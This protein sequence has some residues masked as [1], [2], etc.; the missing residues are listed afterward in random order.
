[1]IGLAH[2]AKME[3]RDSASLISG[4]HAFKDVARAVL[5]FARDSECTGVMSQPKNNLG[6]LPS[7]SLEYRVEEVRIEVEDGWTG[8]P[9]FV[10]G[11]A[12][13]R[14]VEDLLDTG[15]ARAVAEAKDFLRERLNEAPQ[16][17]KDIAEAAGQLGIATRTLDRARKELGITPRKEKDGKWWMSLP[18][19]YDSYGSNGVH[20]GVGSL[21]SSDG[22]SPSQ[23]NP[24]T[25]P[26]V[27]ARAGAHAIVPSEPDWQKLY[28]LGRGQ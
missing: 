7:A 19:E 9:R 23:S 24:P 20:G 26:T 21:S 6:Q 10:M 8:V 1:M 18:G 13:A 16:L 25:S 5:V 2:F 28:W 27:P 12:T 15:R 11:N 3:G 14:S 4:S 17:S 22:D